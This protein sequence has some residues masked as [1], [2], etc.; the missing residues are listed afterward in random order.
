MFLLEMSTFANAH[1]PG[2]PSVLFELSMN[3]YA[4]GRRLVTRKSLVQGTGLGASRVSSTEEAVRRVHFSPAPHS[5][6]GTET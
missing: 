3:E 1:L 4:P 2:A 5:T 6:C